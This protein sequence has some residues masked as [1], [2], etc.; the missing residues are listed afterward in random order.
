[1]PIDS[2]PLRLLQNGK[3]LAQ[4]PAF[5]TKRGSSWT[6]ISFREYAEETRRAAR[7]LV[8]L[9]LESGGCVAI[10]GFNTPE[11]IVFD[12]A[13]MMAGGAPAG[14]YTTCSAEKVQYIVDHSESVVVLVENQEQWEKVKQ[15]R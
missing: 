8:T 10:L 2:I 13:C 5:F 11:W 15:T 3:K 6:P 1:M 12:V 14:I 9:G 4:H 7:A